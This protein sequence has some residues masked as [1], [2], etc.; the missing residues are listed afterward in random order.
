MSYG[1]EVLNW[2]SVFNDSLSIFLLFALVQRQQGQ[3]IGIFVTG[4]GVRK[5]TGNNKMMSEDNKSPEKGRFTAPHT[6]H[7][8]ICMEGDEKFCEILDRSVQERNKTEHGFGQSFYG[9][10]S[11]L[12][13]F[14]SS[15]CMELC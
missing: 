8:L 9:T 14:Q 1:E 6:K 5:G 13:P 2:D 11:G 15:P 12:P 10:R 3:M 7:T 4:P